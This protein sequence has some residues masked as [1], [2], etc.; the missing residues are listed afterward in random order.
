MAYIVCFENQ[1]GKVRLKPT[2]NGSNIIGYCING[3]ITTA[4]FENLSIR[5]S[6]EDSEISTSQ[7]QTFTIDGRYRVTVQENSTDIVAV[8]NYVIE[9]RTVKSQVYGY[10]DSKSRSAVYEKSEV[11]TKDEV[12]TKGEVYAKSEYTT[13]NYTMTVPDDGR[14]VH[15]IITLPKGWSLDNCFIIAA[16][17]KL[18]HKSSGIGQWFDLHADTKEDNLANAGNLYS[19]TIETYNLD[20][21][22]LFFC[23]DISNRETVDNGWICGYK[24]MLLRLLIMKVS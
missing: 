19:H 21:T 8:G 5:T 15:Q 6:L 11:Y 14:Y 20:N 13:L 17:A 7:H 3:D 23:C 1:E 24:T 9:Q 12:Y 16:N 4:V 10:K 18:I 22:K 2:T